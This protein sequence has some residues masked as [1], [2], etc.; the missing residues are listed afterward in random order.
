MEQYQVY[1]ILASCING[2]TD[3]HD[4]ANS[5]VDYFESVYGGSNSNTPIQLKSKFF[6]HFASYYDKLITIPYH[7]I[8]LHSN[9]HEMVPLLHCHKDQF[10]QSH[11]WCH[12]SRNFFIWM[13]RIV[14]ASSNLFLLV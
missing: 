3:G 4:I 12:Q 8:L 1:R 6:S 2:E 7:H 10:D 14:A 5:F 11:C 13:S 9:C